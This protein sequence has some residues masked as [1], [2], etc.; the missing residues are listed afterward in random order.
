MHDRISLNSLPAHDKQC[1]GISFSQF[2]GV[3]KSN[4]FRFSLPLSA[5]MKAIPP[6]SLCPMLSEVNKN[7]TDRM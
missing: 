6:H 2:N 3:I 4:K 5:I 1:D 7:V